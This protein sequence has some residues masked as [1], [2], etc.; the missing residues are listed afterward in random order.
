MPLGTHNL[1]KSVKPA[2]KSIG[3]VFI[4]T[5]AVQT[6]PVY[7]PYA[8]AVAPPAAGTEPTGKQKDTAYG[9]HEAVN[10]RDPSSWGC[11]VTQG[12]KAEAD[13]RSMAKLSDKA[14]NTGGKAK[15]VVTE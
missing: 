13:I 7:G 9:F 14:L 4:P 2:D 6:V 10:P 8:A 1:G 12:A 15:V 5:D 11:G 3:P